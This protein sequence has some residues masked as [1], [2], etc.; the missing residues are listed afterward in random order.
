M[1]LF[2]RE[3]ERETQRHRQRE[4]HAPCGETDA[5]LDPRTPRSWP[6]PKADAQ[7]LSHPGAPH[8][9]KSLTWTSVVSLSL[10]MVHVSFP[11]MSSLMA[12]QIKSVKILQCLTGVYRLKQ[13]PFVIWLLST[14]L[15]SFVPVSIHSFRLH[16]KKKSSSF[17]GGQFRNIMILFMNPSQH[18]KWKLWLIFCPIDS[19]ELLYIWNCNY[20]Q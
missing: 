2:M 11:G 7:P 20:D 14:S 4:K 10:V 19:S 9:L 6:E 16:V 13:G 18:L 1:Y 17:C 15:T 8:S 3:R 12:H 5:G